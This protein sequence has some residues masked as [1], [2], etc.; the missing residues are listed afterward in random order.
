MEA[1]AWIVLILLCMLGMLGVLL[2]GL[3]GSAL[4]VIGAVI[5]KLILPNYLH[6]GVITAIGVLALLAWVIDF[7]GF[8]LGAKW[9]KASKYGLLGATIGGLVGFTFPPLGFLIFP[10]A[11]AFVGEIVA[12]RTLPDAARVGVFTGLGMGVSL[13]IRLGLAAL[14]V[15]I[16]VIDLIA[17]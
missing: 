16:V 1:I 4:I 9:G 15:L 11:G 5:H 17:N 10:I 6:W 12:Y 8:V 7:L 3:P 14:S 13:M 2:P